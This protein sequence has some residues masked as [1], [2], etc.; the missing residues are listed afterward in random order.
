MKST[1]LT[2]SKALAHLNS[3]MKHLCA[4]KLNTSSQLFG[5]GGGECSAQS[6]AVQKR[7]QSQPDTPF[8]PLTKVRRTVERS[9]STVE[10]R[11]STAYQ[12]DRMQEQHLLAFMN[13]GC[14]ASCCFTS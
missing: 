12:D 1:F 2:Q 14:S 9:P 13:R 5:F 3:A 10:Q 8:A 7:Q 11:P 6:S 4:L